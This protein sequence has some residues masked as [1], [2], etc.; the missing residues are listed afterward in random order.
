MMRRSREARVEE[1]GLALYVFIEG[2][3]VDVALVK[4]ICAQ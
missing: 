2:V 3:W 1:R 4:P